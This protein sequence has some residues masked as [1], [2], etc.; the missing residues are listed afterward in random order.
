MRIANTLKL[1]AKKVISEDYLLKRI[2]LPKNYDIKKGALF[3]HSTFGVDGS[4]YKKEIFSI[5]DELGELKQR[6]ELRNDKLFKMSEYEN[7][8][9]LDIDN[10]EKVKNND[11]IRVRH[12]RRCTTKFSNGTPSE[13]HE[14]DTILSGINEKTKY[15]FNRKNVLDK[16]QVKYEQDYET[17]TEY[18]KIKD[19]SDKSKFYSR[20]SYYDKHDNSLFLTDANSNGY[21]KN[22]I[23]WLDHD[24]Y[25]MP[26]FIT[27]KVSLAQSLAHKNKIP[28]VEFEF[29]NL[30]VGKG[31]SYIMDVNGVA[32]IK[33]N[34]NL[35]VDEIFKTLE[36]EIKHANQ[37]RQLLNCLSNLLKYKTDKEIIEYVSKNDDEISFLYQ[38]Y[39]NDYYGSKDA[40]RLF[41]Y[42]TKEKYTLEKVKDLIQGNKNYTSPDKN[43]E[44]Y[45][46]NPIEKD[47]FAKE[48]I[49]QAKKDF[50]SDEY[51][52]L[53][54]PNVPKDS[55]YKSFA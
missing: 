53:F 6:F 40:V 39:L 5:K 17:G 1:L 49:A 4:S 30:P 34:K 16:V 22:L 42:N 37:D 7:S 45:I 2:S 38:R 28:N 54:T 55:L 41:S 24:L 33:I 31:G 20:L 13:Y 25:A 3:E 18:L 21:D 51:R 9:I 19:L 8:S 43:Y 48:K 26:R 11:L 44:L 47:A 50:Y 29:L 10:Y 35:P 23:K 32:K 27:D 15:G 52:F 14:V 12:F 36:H 46:N